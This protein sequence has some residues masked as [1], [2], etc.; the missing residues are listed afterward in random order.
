MNR[1]VFKTLEFD[2]ILQRLCEYSENEKVKERILALEPKTKLSEARELLAETTEA[3]GVILRRGNPP[4]FKITDV[5]S[6]LM[7]AQRGGVMNQKELLGVSRLLKTTRRIKGYILDDKALEDGVVF[8]LAATLEPLKPV[9]TRIDEAILSE[10]EIADSASPELY[11]IRRK[12][13]NLEGKI[14]ETLN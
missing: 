7:R 2:K 13:K 5:V 1:K 12:M 14:R 9:E 8:T 6:A 3:V 10:D 4:G 11:Q